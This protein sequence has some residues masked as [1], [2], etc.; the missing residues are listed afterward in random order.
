MTRSLYL[1][2]RHCVPVIAVTLAIT[3]GFLLER[4]GLY[5]WR[6]LDQAENILYDLRVLVS[7]PGDLDPRV[8]IV[9]IDERSLTEI[10]HWPWSRDKIAR[11]LDRLFEDYGVA[12]VGMDQ[13]FPEP[14]D[15]SGLAVLEA[16]AEGELAGISEYRRKVE[17]VQETL[18]YDGVLAESMRGRPVVLGFYFK[19]Y[20]PAGQQAIAGVLP[21]P[22]PDGERFDRPDVRV[23][24]AQGFGGNLSMLQEAAAGGGHF[25]PWVD[26]DGVIRRV[27]LIYEYGGDYYE[28]L[29]LAVVRRLLEIESISPIFVETGSWL[30]LQFLRVPVDR[31]LQALVPYRGWQGSFPYVSAADVLTG[32]ADRD[33]LRDNIVLVGTTA[34]GLFDLR[35]TPMQK[36][37]AGV[38]VHANLIAGILDQNI[39]QQPAYAEVVDLLALLV[40]GVVLSFLL[41]LVSA[42]WGTVIAV[43]TMVVVGGG[44]LLAWEQANLVLPLAP[45]LMLVAILYVVNM[46]WGF[47]FERRTKR[48]IAATF[49][50]YVPPELIDEMNFDPDSY[51]LAAENREM[52]ILFSDVRGF[53]TIS[54]GLSPTEL[55]ELMNAYLTDMTR[56][57]HE[58][59]GTIDKYMGDAVMAFWGAPVANANHARDALFTG[60]AMLERLHAVREDFVER[61]WP[62][63]HIGVGINTGIVSVGNMGSRFRMAYTVLGDPV[64]LASRLEGLTK[65][66]GVEIIVGE[67]TKKAVPEFVYRELDLVRVKGKA[68]PVAI[69][70]PV[71]K[72]EELSVEE[73]REMEMSS[74]ALAL[75]RRQDWDAAERLFEALL[76]EGSRAPLY[77]LYLDR[78]EAFRHLPPG[79][80]WDGVFTHTTK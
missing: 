4:L 14:D 8:V 67:N 62:A 16:L 12:V 61:G 31:H 33:V 73:I 38:E 28:A 22:I 63:I 57:I 21:A 17:E 77:Q 58:N 30:D 64:N 50:Q 68:E 60:L 20:V 37:Y 59:R 1:R 9:D 70:E 56:L 29:S 65:T 41:P 23:R 66:Y 53:T 36:Q 6:F 24:S 46:S 19:D 7:M 35:T 39:R 27:P 5:H 2:I 44:N 26:E 69:Y 43:G 52:T 15:S 25:T 45:P 48:Q 3:G 79:A 74:E 76:R 49:G 80:D 47:F 55:S 18:D 32:T 72:E 40:L 75:Y 10:G 34:P 42:V 13:V 54:E 78:I 51:T 71:A 11:L